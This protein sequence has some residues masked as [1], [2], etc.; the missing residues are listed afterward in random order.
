MRVVQVLSALFA[1]WLLAGCG[2]RSTLSV[3][4]L[5]PGPV[6]VTGWSV[7]GIRPFQIE[8]MSAERRPVAIRGWPSTQ[9]LAMTV[10]T[11]LP[12]Q[13]AP[14]SWEVALTRPGPYVLRVIMEEGNP[15]FERVEGDRALRHGSSRIRVKRGPQQ[16]GG[17]AP[18]PDSPP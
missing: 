4:N 18:E 11:F 8:P 5:T 9:D 13:P 12:D 1:V 2:G 14:R 3:E 16:L 10:T 17:A 6:R 7:K 15:V